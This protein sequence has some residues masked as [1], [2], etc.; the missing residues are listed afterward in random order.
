MR[1]PA[2]NSIR[3]SLELSL[4]ELMQDLRV[5]LVSPAA[6]AGPAT[7]TRTLRPSSRPGWGTVTWTIRP[8]HPIPASAI[9]MLRFSYSGGGDR[10]SFI[11]SL[12]PDVCF[13]AG[14][15][16][17]W[18]PEIEESLPE[19][20]P[21]LRGLRGT[22]TLKF[23]VPA[24]FVVHSQGVQRGNSVTKSN[25]EFRFEITSPT[26]FSFAAAKYMVLK[27]SGRP[28]ISLYSLR[29]R[30][31][32][33]SYLNGSAKVIAALTREFGAYPHALFAVVE[34]P[35]EEADQAGFAG[36]SLEGFMLA[37]SEFLD[38]DFN[39]A[40]F[41]HEVS[42]QWWGNLV[43]NRT[44]EGRWMLTEAMAQYGS[45]RA[46]EMIEGAASAERYR[47][48]GYPGYY[49]DQSA[50]GYFALALARK[51]H[52]LSNLPPE[53]DESHVLSD[54]KGS[55]VWDMLSR[56]IGRQRLSRILQN[57]ARKHAY[58]RIGWREFLN[59]I[60]TGANRSLQ[61]FYE[62]WLERTGAPDFHIDW[63]QSGRTLSGVITQPS[64]HYEASLEVEIKNNRGQRF[65]KTVR[66][67]G[68]ETPF[69]FPVQHQIESVTL[70]PHYLVLHWLPEYR[71]KEVR[72]A[73]EL[74]K[75][76]DRRPEQRMRMRDDSSR[77][78]LCLNSSV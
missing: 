55:I 57:I 64:P 45:L 6:S 8:S 50:K 59:E 17:A 12:A 5:E 42:H 75:S 43:R 69:S 53:G 29:P 65:M 13:A 18:Y 14:I 61:W 47:R 62:Q 36:A 78:R 77:P 31:N 1:I 74:A 52:P 70:D 76:I 66:V 19:K 38:K 2:A 63:K 26:F 11:F 23:S 9:V 68:A 21:K 16:T 51:D 3:E 33:Q 56:E 54:S 39:T 30:A 22:G 34:V 67:R 7:L 4:S 25:S 71:A 48:I 15:T 35:N 73:Y 44:S 49:S 60:E 28:P 24:G 27:K 58:Q 46:V 20:S 72:A 32:G 41:G 40:Y 10:T 37:N